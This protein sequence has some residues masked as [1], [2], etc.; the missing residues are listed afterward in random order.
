M[1]RLRRAND[2]RQR[3]AVTCKIGNKRC[4]KVGQRAVFADV[5]EGGGIVIFEHDWGIFDFLRILKDIQLTLSKRHH[6]P[7]DFNFTF[8]THAQ[9]QMIGAINGFGLSDVP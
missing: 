3:S 8:S 2:N 1:P 9:I 5:S 6:T 7:T 4:N